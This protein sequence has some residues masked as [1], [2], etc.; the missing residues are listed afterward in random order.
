MSEGAKRMQ[1][2]FLVGMPPLHRDIQYTAD[3]LITS[4][5]NSQICTVISS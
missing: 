3:L 4:T 1:E 5:D 2:N